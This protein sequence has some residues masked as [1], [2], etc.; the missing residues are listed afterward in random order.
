MEWNLQGRIASL[1][2]DPD[3]NAWRRSSRHANARIA[4]QICVVQFRGI[5]CF[6]SYPRNEARRTIGADDFPRSSPGGAL[7]WL[8][9]FP[10]VWALMNYFGM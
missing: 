7:T 1:T 9:I 10:V 6:L 3:R 2:R 5:D 4:R 8:A